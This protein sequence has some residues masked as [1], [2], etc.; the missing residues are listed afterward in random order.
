MKLPLLL[1]SFLYMTCCCVISC[2]RMSKT[3]GQIYSYNFNRIILLVES[4]FSFIFGCFLLTWELWPAVSYRWTGWVWDQLF[5]VGDCRKITNHF[6]GIC[7]VYPNFIK[8]NRRMSTCSRL[9]LQTLGSQPIMP[10]N[11]PNHCLR[12]NISV[13]SLVWE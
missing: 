9:D 1:L 10:K 2:M 5:E 6:R 13:G 7:R 11:L 12:T 8:Q 4:H 3:A